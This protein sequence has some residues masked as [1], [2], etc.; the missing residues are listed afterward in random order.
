MKTDLIKVL[1]DQNVKAE[2][3]IIRIGDTVRV[4]IKIKEGAKERQ[5]ARRRQ[6]NLHRPSYLLWRGRGKGL[7]RAFPQ[8]GSGGN[9]PQGQGASCKA[10]LPA[11]PC[12][13]GC[14]GQDQA[15]IS[16]EISLVQTKGA[17][18]PLL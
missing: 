3:P 2:A 11:R 1:N 9:R 18:K 16:A 14:K 17:G 5:E 4:H 13:Q 6:R 12:W 15:V 8:R 10:V 7:P